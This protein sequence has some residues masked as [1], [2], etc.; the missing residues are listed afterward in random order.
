MAIKSHQQKLAQSISSLGP[1]SSAF[2]P[3]LT[4]KLNEIGQTA[5]DYYAVEPRLML[6]AAGVD[7]AEA[8]LNE[9]ALQEAEAWAA[10]L[11]QQSNE[12]D[13]DEIAAKVNSS[14]ASTQ[15]MFIDS[16]VENYADIISSLGPNIDVYVL[17]GDRDGVE[18][19]AEVLADKENVD[20]IHIVSHGRS[21]TLDLGDT[22]LTEA[23]IAGKHADE[24]AVIKNALSQDADLLIYGCDF[25]AQAR[26]ES[27]V[28]ALSL[29][30]G[31]DIAA[32][33]D[34]TGA[35]E[36]G[37]DWDLE[38]AQGAIEA[39]TLEFEEFMD[40]LGIS[41][42][43]DT[44]TKV[45]AGAPITI[46]PRD[47]DVDAE[48]GDITITAIVDTEGDGDTHV[49]ANAGDQAV[50]DSG[51]IVELRA[52]GRLKVLV[53]AGSTETAEN[54]DYIVED[55]DGNTDQATVELVIGND[56][57]AAKEIGF[58]GKV[59]S[60]QTNYGDTSQTYLR[61]E[62]GDNNYTVFW[63]CLLYTSDA[64]DD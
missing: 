4:K 44:D 3:D 61:V 2:A 9:A 36:L 10:G 56:F 30:T 38:V 8:A 57:A 24:M 45:I 18:Q 50:L 64:A 22:K 52:D 62:D 12:T 37:G 63:D 20:A 27:A 15:I 32:S 16:G 21:G 41:A 46:D 39:E 25:G 29:A 43:D 6:D 31:A 1:R 58:V 23:S 53:A 49:L 28:L 11:H 40:V 7:T 34:L 54:F 35:H 14:A 13:A 60:Y 47:N 26:G 59:N 55:A 19:M 17:T 51:T 33:D 48:G 42:A 5:P